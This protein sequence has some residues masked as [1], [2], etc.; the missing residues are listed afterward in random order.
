MRRAVVGS[1]GPAIAEIPMLDGISSMVSQA[2]RLGGG[3]R[4]GRERQ[5]ERER[6]T[7]GETQARE[8]RRA[9]CAC[10]ETVQ[11]QCSDLLW[12]CCERWIHPKPA[13]LASRD[14]EQMV[15]GRPDERQTRPAPE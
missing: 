7:E 6:P 15:C 3:G 11:S 14:A 12:L 10:G 8:A 9:E 2:R 1:I 13:A 5:R 4:E